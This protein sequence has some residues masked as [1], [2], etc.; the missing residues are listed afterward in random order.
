MKKRKNT[1]KN[2]VVTESFLDNRLS[3]LE[4]SLDKRFEMIVA[5]I[6]KRF[7]RLFIYLDHRFEP[8]EKMAEDYPKFKDY[9]YDK[10]DWLVGKYQKLDDELTIMS[11]RHFII[12]D[13]I[14]NHDGRI[15]K[16]EDKHSKSN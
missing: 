4:K 2:K 10:L 3:I 11:E 1:K 6:D 16:L 13:K 5:Y 12:T 7:E 9:V 14:N 8:L 15:T